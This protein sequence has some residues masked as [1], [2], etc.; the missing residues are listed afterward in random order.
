MGTPQLLVSSGRGKLANIVESL[1]TMNQ[2]DSNSS[3]DSTAGDDATGLPPR[4]ASRQTPGNSDGGKSEFISGYEIIGQ[5]GAGGMGTVWRAR[6]DSSRREVALKLLNAGLLTSE[7]AKRRFEREIEVASLL[8][9]PNIARVYESGVAQGAYFYSMELVEGL[10]LHEFIEQHR[11]DKRS[12]LALMTIVCRAIQYAHQKGVIH[13]DLKPSNILVDTGNSPHIVDFGLGKLIDEQASFSTISLQ[14]DW[15]GT[16]AYM[17]PEQ[18]AGLIAEI[19]TRS[20]VYSLGVILYQIL[21]GHLPHDPSGG[22]LA[23]LE[24]VAHAEIVRPKVAAADIDRDLEALLLKALAKVPEDRYASVGELADDI[25]NYLN[26]DPLTARRPTAIYFLRKKFNKHRIPIVAAVIVIAGIISLVVHDSIRMKQERNLALA[27]AANAE[28]LRHTSQLNLAESL[29]SNG[30]GLVQQS[31]WHDAATR[32]SEALRIQTSEGVS[33]SNSTLGFLD[34]I[35]HAPDEW[36]KLTANAQSPIAPIGVLFDPDERTAWAELPSGVAQSY[37]LLTGRPGLETGQAITDSE[38]SSIF[39]FSEAGFIYRLRVRQESEETVSSEIQKVDLRNGSAHTTLAWAGCSSLHAAITSDGQH[40][41]TVGWTAHAATTP[42]SWNLWLVDADANL[43]QYSLMTHAEGIRAIA[44]SRDGRSVATGDTQG[45]IRFWNTVTH[46]ELHP[47]G[48]DYEIPGA[49]ASCEA[50]CVMFTPDGSGVVAGG[51]DGSVGILALSSNG[52]WRKFGNSDARVVSLAFSHDRQL[53]LSGDDD[54]MLCLWD[55]NSA[56]LRRTFFAGSHIVSMRFSPDDREILASTINGSIHLWPVDLADQ[57]TLCR[58][59]G[60]VGCVAVSPD[61]LLAAVGVSNDVRVIDVATG[62]CIW[63]NTLTATVISLAFSENGSTLDAA[64]S[65]GAVSRFEVFGQWRRIAGCSPGMTFR[66]LKSV[67]PKIMADALKKV[68]LI[69]ESDTAIDLTS[70]GAILMNVKSGTRTGVIDGAFAPV[71]CISADSHLVLAFVSNPVRKLAIMDSA[72]VLLSTISLQHY[73][74]ATA[75]ALSPNCHTVYVASD[76][77]IIH[78]LDLHSGAEFES[79]S[80]RQQKVI[81]MSV[82]PDGNL[83]LTGSQNGMLQLWRA[84]DG[85]KLRTVADGLG[86][87]SSTAF[88]RTGDMVICPDAPD[89]SVCIWKMSYPA[90]LLGD[91]EKVAQARRQIATDASNPSAAATLVDWYAL[92]GAFAWGKELLDSRHIDAG[93]GV[94]AARCRWQANDFAGAVEDFDRLIQHNAS[95]LSVAYLQACRDAAA[96]Q[97]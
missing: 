15:A 14:G 59:A 26:G 46:A 8:E 52:Q 61:E 97:E 38:V 81:S 42:R 10:A 39:E 21:T 73:R 56:E 49:T 90:Q 51:S 75:I 57:S 28:A 35:R 89:N 3:E 82:S 69:P 20:D 76:D 5:L 37:D 72:G 64:T 36:S 9:H 96:Q 93:I 23:V 91:A 87:V 55:V 70:C 95:G 92:Q 7:V 53:L 32:Y 2:S 29:I 48:E 45:H 80:S 1:G 68:I 25:D 67:P 18:A 33:T 13:R 17:S 19:D 60:T 50:S 12:S 44:F 77:S 65:D 74:P 31:R 6:R 84:E 63:S 83:I 30:D 88:S 85:A 11:L 62:Y 79:I 71:G 16:P 66:G 86:L 41:A 34:T 47:L 27:A 43:S 24:R 40:L 4:S 22:N 94:A 58:V 54:G 78:A